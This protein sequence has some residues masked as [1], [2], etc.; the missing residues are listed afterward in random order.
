MTN[1]EIF[2]YA[3]MCMHQCHSFFLRREGRT[4]TEKEIAIEEKRKERWRGYGMAQYILICTILSFPLFSRP[5]IFPSF[6]APP[7]HPLRQPLCSPHG[8][9][10]IVPN[11]GSGSGGS[12][13]SP[14]VDEGGTPPISSGIKRWPFTSHYLS[15][16]N[17][18]TPSSQ[19]SCLPPRSTQAR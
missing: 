9:I 5:L 19:R 17:S 8:S 11:D 3:Q 10:Q 12:E 1:T 18:R 7:P 14:L 2:P 4:R 6:S 15:T 16:W 13:S